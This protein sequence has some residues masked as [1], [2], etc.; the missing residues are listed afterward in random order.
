MAANFT[1][2]TQYPGLLQVGVTQTQEVVFVGIT[3]IPHGTYL[4]FP[5]P[6]VGYNA[7]EV[8]QQAT[9]WA[10]VFELVWDEPYVTGVQW[11]QQVNPSNQLE[12]AVVVTVSSTSGNSANQL[13]LPYAKLNPHD[14]QPLIHNLHTTLDDV[15]AG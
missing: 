13:T 8:H 9:G 15:E 11:I 12:N 5:L 6:Q 7:A 4:E 14:Y 3:T 1:V 10:T 2:T